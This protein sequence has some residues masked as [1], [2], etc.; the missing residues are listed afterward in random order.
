MPSGFTFLNFNPNRTSANFRA[1]E[2]NPAKIIQ[3]IT[4]G[5]PIDTAAAEPA[6]FPIPADAEIVAVSAWKAET[7]PFFFLTLISLCS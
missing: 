3:K 6:T 5:P 4:P 1:I 7:S 2:K